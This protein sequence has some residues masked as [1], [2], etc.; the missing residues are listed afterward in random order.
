M[1]TKFPDFDKDIRRPFAVHEYCYDC[2]EFYHGCNAW[3]GSKSFD[4]A[5][6]YA[7][8]DVMPGTY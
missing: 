8:P 4:C 3:P 2:A 7:L 1:N 5:D 6:Y